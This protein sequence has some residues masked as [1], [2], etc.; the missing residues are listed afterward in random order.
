MT[1][2]ALKDKGDEPEVLA[3][4]A[5]RY[6]QTFFMAGLIRDNGFESPLNRGTFY[7]CRDAQGRLVGVALIGHFTLVETQSEEALA[8]FA[9]CAKAHPFADV[10][11]GDPESVERFWHHYAPAGRAADLAS[12]KLLFELREPAAAGEAVPGLR[13]A[14]LA[15]LPQVMEAQALM[16]YEEKG[17]N[18]LASDPDGFRQRC[19]RRIEQGRVW[20]WFRRGRLIFKADVMAETPETVYLEGVYV[21]PEARGKGF[22][23]RCV[24]Q[25]GRHFAART[26]SLCLLVNEQNK[27]AHAFYEKSGFSLTG[28]YEALYLQRS[29]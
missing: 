25:L 16:L 2:H 29:H 27:R 22:G 5:E 24:A 18:P 21:S 8:A 15:E 6:R 19:A 12:R 17:V 14:T 9:R 28:Y 23:R 4:L 20:V 10:I 26:R 7:A 13:R 11:A 3:F 1:I